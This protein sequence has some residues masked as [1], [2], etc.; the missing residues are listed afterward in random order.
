MIKLNS[1]NFGEISQWSLRDIKKIFQRQ[2]QQSEIPGLFKRITLCHN[3]L[4][5]TMGSV[6]KKDIPNV[7]EKVIKIIRDVFDLDSNEVYNLN[8]CF[9]S[10]AEL[11]YD[12]YNG[13][14]IFKGTCSISF[15]LFKQIFRIDDRLNIEESPIMKLNSLLEDLFQIS[16]S[17]DK[18]SIL[19]K[20]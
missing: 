5:Y 8:E 17:N 20:W 7:K 16:L 6:S 2:I 1:N 11:K 19:L 13:H 18:E 15:Y 4:F 12:K 10:K 14:C 3:I 9:N